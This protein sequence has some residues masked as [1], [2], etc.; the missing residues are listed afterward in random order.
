[1]YHR[2]Q[3]DEVLATIP[4]SVNIGAFAV[5]M[6]EVRAVLSKKHTEVADRITQLIAAVAKQNALRLHEGYGAINK[7]LTRVPKNIE[8]RCRHLI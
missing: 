8:V 4:P 6:A 5:N 2:K 7:E 3:H 1:V